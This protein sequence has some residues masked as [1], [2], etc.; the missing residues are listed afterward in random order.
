MVRGLLRYA[1]QRNTP[2]AR[3]ARRTRASPLQE[4]PEDPRGG[5]PDGTRRAPGE[6]PE[7]KKMRY[8]REYMPE[9]QVTKSAFKRLPH[10][11][12][13]VFGIFLERSQFGSYFYK[14]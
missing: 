6:P 8:M 14:D 7:A 1:R 4:P 9:N 11:E 12:K 10:L 3:V 5:V 13:A 2:A